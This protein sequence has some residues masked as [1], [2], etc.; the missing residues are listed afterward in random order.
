MVGEWVS[1]R[2]R[3]R[4][5]ERERARE[6]ESEKARRTERQ[7]QSER[8]RGPSVQPHQSRRDPRILGIHIDRYILGILVIYLDQ[9]ESFGLNAP[10]PPHRNAQHTHL[11][12]GERYMPRIRKSSASDTAQISCRFHS[13][14]LCLS[15]FGPEILVRRRMPGSSAC[16]GPML[17]EIGPPSAVHL[18]RHKW[19]G[20]FTQLI[21]RSKTIFT[22]LIRGLLAARKVPRRGGPAR[23]AHRRERRRSGLH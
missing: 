5:R 6:R 1:D 11:W 16:W 9:Y 15:L 10:V 12:R 20:T 7:R 2:E 13:R 23:R 22:Q 14:P 17:R 3:E 21:Y 4:E 8:E 19:P 18:S